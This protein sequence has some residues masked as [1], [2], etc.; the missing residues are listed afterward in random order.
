MKSDNDLI[1]VSLK[2]LMQRKKQ[3]LKKTRYPK[4]CCVFLLAE[5]LWEWDKSTGRL[6][7][8]IGCIYS[9][10]EVYIYIL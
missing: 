5:G 4:G 1:S 10:Y 8:M 2:K 3:C 7:L 6:P 9:N